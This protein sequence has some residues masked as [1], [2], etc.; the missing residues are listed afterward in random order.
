MFRRFLTGLLVGTMLINSG[1]TTI[2]A[3]TVEAVYNGP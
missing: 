2:L 3:E 1:T